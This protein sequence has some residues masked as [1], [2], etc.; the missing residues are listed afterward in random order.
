M[1]KVVTRVYGSD[2]M[3][4]LYNVSLVPRPAFFTAVGKT[5]PHVVFS[6]AA[7]KRKES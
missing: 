4:T 7:K 1:V 5:L 3:T 6:T 2:P